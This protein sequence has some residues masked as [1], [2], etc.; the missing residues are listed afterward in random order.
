LKILKVEIMDFS[1]SV[2][3]KCVHPK[4]HTWSW[5]GLR[6]HWLLQVWTIQPQTPS[7]S[8]WDRSPTPQKIERPSCSK[9]KLCVDG[10]CQLS[11]YDPPHPAKRLDTAPI[12]SVEPRWVSKKPNG[13]DINRTWTQS[14]ATWARY[15]VSCPQ[16]SQS[17]RG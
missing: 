13:H 11:A 1:K 16:A 5:K 7:T 3:V 4:W 8:E 15:Q 6:H 17:Y 9:A 12:K 10:S 14:K 2:L